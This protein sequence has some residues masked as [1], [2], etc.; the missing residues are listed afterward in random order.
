MHWQI[1]VKHPLSVQ[2]KA[3][4]LCIDYNVH[5]TAPKTLETVTAIHNLYYISFCYELFMVL[6]N[7]LC[8]Q[9][10][11]SRVSLNDRQG[12][13]FGTKGYF[14]INFILHFANAFLY[15]KGLINV[16]PGYAVFYH[17]YMYI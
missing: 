9:Q 15:S 8:M 6:I 11:I 12:D 4:T 7:G 3:I 2:Q 16:N 14:N 5:R 13:L 1:A 17:L 10:H